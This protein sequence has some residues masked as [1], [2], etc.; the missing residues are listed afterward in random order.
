MPQQI[1]LSTPVLLVQKRYFSAQTMLQTLVALIVLGGAL[2][3][4]GVY[5][6][7]SATAQ[8]KL[9]AAAQAQELIRL[10]LAIN[11]APSEAGTRQLEQELAAARQRLAERSAALDEMR[12][13]LLVPGQGHAA[14]MQ[15]V[16]RTIPESA[17]VTEVLADASRIE[18]RGLT[19]D[20]AALNDWIARLGQSP[21]LAGQSLRKVRVESVEAAAGRSAGTTVAA[22][23]QA[24]GGRPAWTFVLASGGPNA[25]PFAEAKSP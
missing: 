4:Y 8:M 24:S 15:L 6:L 20:P 7:R 14:R 10:R 11:P 9:T 3:A 16:A 1:N 2:T 21:L 13:G 18:L 23:A 22:Q 12:R 17:W 25:Q 19:H 5:S